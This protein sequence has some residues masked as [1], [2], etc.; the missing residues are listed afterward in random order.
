MAP[1]HL[2][3]MGAGG[4]IPTQPRQCLLSLAS[5]GPSGHLSHLT[6][7]ETE[8]QRQSTEQG[9]QGPSHSGSNEQWGHADG[10]HREC[11]VGIAARGDSAADGGTG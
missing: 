11:G 7:G 8:A 5:L 10:F 6:D 1:E 2:P 4:S 9:R 3:E